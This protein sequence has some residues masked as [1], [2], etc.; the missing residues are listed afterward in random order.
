[1]KESSGEE[2]APSTTEPHGLKKVPPKDEK[3]VSRQK[4]SAPGT[5]ILSAPVSVQQMQ[6]P[7]SMLLSWNKHSETS[8]GGSEAGTAVRDTANS[9][10]SA[11][12]AAAAAGSMI[13][14]GQLAFSVSLPKAPAA[15]KAAPVSAAG[16]APPDKTSHN[17][18]NSAGK[19]HSDTSD[20]NDPKSAKAAALESTPKVQTAENT[21]A[22]AN[23]PAGIATG[24]HPSQFTPYSD[25]HLGKT[26]SPPAAAEAVKTAD[27]PPTPVS[28]PPQSIDLK[29]SG[30]DNSQVDVRV[31]QRAGDVQV[32]VRTPDGDLAQSLRQ[33]LPELSDRLAQSGAG[34]EIFSPTT[35]QASAD[36]SSNQESWNSDQSEARQQQQRN[37]NGQSNQP[38][39]ENGSSNWR[40]EFNNAEKEDR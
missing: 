16:I 31:S 28:R 23:I 11:H 30:A 36:T 10:A 3:E 38:Q 15:D 13:Q 5:A 9:A 17:E 39:E 27:L 35:A 12:V 34:G 32:T 19:Q 14:K 25:A 22:T 7:R 26:T 8:G 20:S 29:V 37:T 33:H 4:S 18:K 1:M 2:D 24:T 40:N 21:T 6:D